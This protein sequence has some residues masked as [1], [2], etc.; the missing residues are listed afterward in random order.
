MMSNDG[1]YVLLYQIPYSITKLFGEICHISKLF[2]ILGI[3]LTRFIYDLLQ[4][5]CILQL[6]RE[7]MEV[8]KPTARDG[9]AP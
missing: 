7:G 2:Y 3:L 6:L 9:I 5:T 1:I 4:H 8:A